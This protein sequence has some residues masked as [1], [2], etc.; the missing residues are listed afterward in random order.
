MGLVSFSEF[1]SPPGLFALPLRFLLEDGRSSSSVLVSA[2]ADKTKV[3]DI[4]SS[5]FNQFLLL[6]KFQKPT[7]FIIT[8]LLFLATG[9]LVL[10]TFLAAVRPKHL[11]G[12][13]H[14]SLVPQQQDIIFHDTVG[15]QEPGPATGEE[16]VT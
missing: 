11:D 9:A 2:N 15:R 13:H 4:I 14:V 6:S 1:S 12:E 3:T 7:R 8:L 10:V 5:Q 16:K